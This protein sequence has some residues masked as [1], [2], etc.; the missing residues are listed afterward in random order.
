M[1][2]NKCVRL[3]VLLA[4]A[5]S[6]RAQQDTPK[7]P[8]IWPGPSFDPRTMPGQYVYLTPEKNALIIYDPARVKEKGLGARCW[9]LPLLNEA[10]P[11]IHVEIRRTRSG[12]LEYE[13][14]LENEPGA[15]TPIGRFH[16]AMEPGDPVFHMRHEYGPGRGWGATKLPPHPDFRIAVQTALPGAPNGGY[17]GWFH[18]AHTNLLYPGQ[19]MGGFILEATYRPGFTTAYIG[20]GRGWDIDLNWPEEVF[21]QIAFLRLPEWREQYLLTIGPRYRPG[22]PV[23]TIVREYLTGINQWVGSGRLEASSPFVKAV[24]EALEAWRA[25]PSRPP[26]ILAEP[27]TEAET[28][29]SMALKFL[30]EESKP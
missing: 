30:L 25:D 6:V 5:S 16:L 24:R 20:P 4:L 21:E 3:L 29:L 12:T 2:W 7:I 15:R 27:Q 14:T 1:S 23:E 19:K 18:Y 17:R 22:T 10:K 9:L 8:P 13:Y 26:R 28:E 11:R